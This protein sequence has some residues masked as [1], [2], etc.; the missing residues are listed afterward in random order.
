MTT[1]KLAGVCVTLLVVTAGC[2]KG[3]ERYSVKGKVTWQGKPIP[4][5]EVIFEPDPSKSNRGP[6]ARAPIVDGVYE[7]LADKGT[8]PGPVVVRIVGNDG[9]PNK[10]NPK[11][12]F[13]FSEYTT[14]AEIPNEDTSLDF[15]V[16]ASHK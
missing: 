8:V 11:G 15:E 9:K 3:L 7:T 16:P 1:A 14:K 6:Q 2:Q 4:A 12:N 13:L 5:G 10:E